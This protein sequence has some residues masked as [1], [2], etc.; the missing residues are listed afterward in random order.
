MPPALVLQELSE[1]SAAH[2]CLLHVAA[3]DLVLGLLQQQALHMPGLQQCSKPG[4][5][6]LSGA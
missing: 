2:N 3:L 1:L 4:P 6:P 5:V